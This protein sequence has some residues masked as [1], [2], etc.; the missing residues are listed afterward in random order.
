M[1]PQRCLHR[2]AS[3]PNGL[4]LKEAPLHARAGQGSGEL[5]TLQSEPSM[6]LLQSVTASHG[7][8]ASMPCT[9]N[10][11]NPCI[12]CTSRSLDTVRLSSLL[13]RLDASPQLL[14]AS[15]D[16]PE[17]QTLM[18]QSQPKSSADMSSRPPDMSLVR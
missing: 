16:L 12:P 4:T 8:E 11:S 7:S 5:N 3:T 17:R 1:P 10:Q 13:H 15:R 6:P 18:L 14:V 9:I 2:H